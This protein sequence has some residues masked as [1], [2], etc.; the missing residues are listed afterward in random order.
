MEHKLGMQIKPEDT[1]YVHV[2]G[3]Q[4]SLTVKKSDPV[5]GIS[6]AENGTG[7]IFVRTITPSGIMVSAPASIYHEC[8][9]YP[10]IVMTSPRRGVLLLMFLTPLFRTTRGWRSGNTFIRSMEPLWME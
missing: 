7:L 3:E 2:R 6:L 10:H 5:L 1:L 4:R 8:R 9:S